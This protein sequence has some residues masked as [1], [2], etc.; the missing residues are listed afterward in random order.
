MCLRGGARGLRAQGLLP[1]GGADQQQLSA[2]LR[3]FGGPGVQ[4][5]DG[6]RGRD[7]EHL[8]GREISGER[9]KSSDRR[10]PG[11]A[12]GWDPHL[13]TESSLPP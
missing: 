8:A 7:G 5:A 9:R 11:P 12:L 10:L 1:S 2:G 13:L 4:E 6:L 3:G